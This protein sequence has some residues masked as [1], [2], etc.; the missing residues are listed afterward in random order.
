MAGNYFRAAVGIQAHLT[1][2]GGP[3]FS[4]AL[5]RRFLGDIAALGLTIEITE[6]DVTD[7]NAPADSAAR[8]N[9]R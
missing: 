9:I 1:A 3:P 5:L 6:L 8:V 2:V 7:E 4:A